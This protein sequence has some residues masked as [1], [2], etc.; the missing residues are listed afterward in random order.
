[1]FAPIHALAALASLRCRSGVDLFKRDRMWGGMRFNYLIWT[2]L[3]ALLLTASPSLAHHDEIPDPPPLS[4]SQPLPTH[5]RLDA[6]TVTVSGLSSGGFFAH[7]FHVAFSQSV[8]GAAI[9]AGGPY[10]CVEVID[11]PVWPF[12]K[13]DPASAAVVAC[14]HYLGSRFW[15][16]RPKPPRAADVRQL[17]DAAHQAG[18]IDDP[19]NLADDRVWLF[20]GELDRVVPAEVADALADLYRLLGVDTALHVEPGDRERPANHGFPVAHIAGESRFP[21]RDCAEHA[22]P[23]VI[24]CGYDAAGL[25]LGHLYPEG[26]L[27]EPV[28]AHDAGSLHVFDQTEFFEPSRPAGLSGVGYI[29]IPDACQTELCRLHVAFHGCRQNA[30]AQGGDRIHDDFLRHA[31]YNRWAGANR[32]VVLYPQATEAAGNPQACWDFWGYSGE[33]WR[34]REG[35][36]MRAARSMIER[37][38]ER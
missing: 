36:Q 15:G 16:V 32:I 4:V 33:G 9:L 27:P 10:G 5:L 12:R 7:Q 30:D 13:L 37:L 17:I 25:L 35:I 2:S 23:C 20:R 24:E 14:T 29:Y 21:P 34:T 31:G 28:D 1:M 18:E 38:L 8:A 3:A 26:F 22:P 19:T 11:N 6:T